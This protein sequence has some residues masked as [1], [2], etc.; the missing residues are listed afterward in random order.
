MGEQQREKLSE[1]YALEAVQLLERAHKVAYFKGSDRIEHLKKDPDLDL[2]RD[3]DDFR[4]L[5]E[6]IEAG[7]DEVQVE[8]GS[9]EG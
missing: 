1:E 4:T 3:R 6:E 9:A 5:L 8:V 2:L 7:R